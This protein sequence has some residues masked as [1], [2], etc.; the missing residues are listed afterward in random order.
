M[1]ILKTL[2]LAGF[3]EKNAK[4]MG[5]LKEREFE[6]CCSAERIEAIAIQCT[7]DMPIPGEKNLQSIIVFSNVF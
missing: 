1:R 2:E 7:F 6:R 4:I 5:I 3:A